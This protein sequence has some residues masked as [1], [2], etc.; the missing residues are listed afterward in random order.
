MTIRRYGGLNNRT[1]EPQGARLGKETNQRHVSILGSR[2]RTAE[3]GFTTSRFE[4]SPS[5]RRR[6]QM[7]ATKDTQ[8]EMK[9][10]SAL[11]RR[12]L[13]FRVH[14]SVPGVIRGKVDV[15]FPRARVAVFID[16]CF[17]HGCEKH[18]PL[19]QTNTDFW[20]KKIHQNRIRDRRFNQQLRRAGWMVIRVW[21]HDD[22]PEAADKVERIVK[23]RLTPA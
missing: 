1:I 11:H 2:N 19:P 18:R 16:G 14:V 6:M 9:L 4:S 21:E 20:I 7:Q 5:V 22:V 10:R 13:R 8:P 23:E 3:E 17:W 12:G 15:V